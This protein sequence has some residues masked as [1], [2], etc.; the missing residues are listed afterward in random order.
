MHLKHYSYCFWVTH[1]RITHENKLY[2]YPAMHI[3]FYERLSLS[4]SAF[5][6]HSGREEH[7]TTV[8]PGP[9]MYNSKRKYCLCG[10]LLPWRKPTDRQKKEKKVS[11]F[12]CST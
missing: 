8:S 3:F 10:L 11:K 12:Y 7:Q 1:K 9:Q 4:S 5:H 2:L 6:K